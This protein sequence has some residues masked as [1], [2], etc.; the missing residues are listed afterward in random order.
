MD[1]TEARVEVGAEVCCSIGAEGCCAIAEEGYG[2]IVVH[3][4][5]VGVDGVKGRGAFEE[6][7]P[8]FVWLLV[9]G[10]V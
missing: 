10:A 4:H 8:W 6:E 1:S 7:G 5:G 3:G 2:N 9:G